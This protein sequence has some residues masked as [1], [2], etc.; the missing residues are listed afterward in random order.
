MNQTA[1]TNLLLHCKLTGLYFGLVGSGLSTA[2]YFFT[3]YL[4]YILY[5]V[6]YTCI[7]CAYVRMGSHRCTS[8]A[9][10]IEL[11]WLNFC[12]ATAPTCTAPPRYR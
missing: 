10:R 7:L 2:Y 11:Q 1:V 12:C 4:Q 3:I 9:R 5:C 8:P 6:W